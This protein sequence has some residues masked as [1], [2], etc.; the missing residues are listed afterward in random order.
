[1][2]KVTAQI[3]GGSIKQLEAD[4]VSD[5]KALL[6]AENHSASVNGSN[7]EDNYEL[8]DYEFVSLAPKVKGA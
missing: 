3:I 6:D 1:M 4:T 7:E 2:A 8:S 5:V